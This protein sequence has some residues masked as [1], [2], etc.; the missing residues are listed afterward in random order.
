MGAVCRFDSGI[1]IANVRVGGAK[2]WQAF[3][4]H[5]VTLELVKF[6]EH[7]RFRKNQAMPRVGLAHTL[8]CVAMTDARAGTDTIE[9]DFMTSPIL[10]EHT[11]LCFSGGGELVV[12]RLKKG[13][14]CVANQKNAS[15]A[16]P[17]KLCVSNKRA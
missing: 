9:A 12:I 15:H 17:E 6:F 4:Q 10:S 1:E 13:S 16:S 14:L 11:S 2:L 7:L 8:F 5:N 3:F